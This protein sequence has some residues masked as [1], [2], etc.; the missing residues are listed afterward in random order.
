MVSVPEIVGLIEGVANDTTVP[1]NIRRAMDEAKA[2]LTS[3]DELTVKVS[4]AIYSIESVSEDV[5]MPSHA[6]MQLWN[7]LSAL[8][9]IKK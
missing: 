6:R 7:I 8:E 2:R 4:A 5:N 3:G 9:S 1:K